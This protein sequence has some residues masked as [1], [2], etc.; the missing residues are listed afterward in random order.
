[1]DEP[2]NHL[3]LPA[4]LWL[5]DY[6]NSIT[7]T[8]IVIVS[9]DRNFLN[10]TV[11]EIIVLQGQQ[12][13]YHMGNYDEYL[14]STGEQKLHRARLREALGKKKQ[15]AAE[16]LEAGLLQAKKK[17]DEKKVAQLASRKKKLER[18]GM[19][20]NEAGHRFKLSRDRIGYFTTVRSQ[21]QEEHVDP[22]VHWRIEEP[23]LITQQSPLMEIESV[24]FSYGSRLILKNVTM[25]LALG[26][27][28]AIC[29][30]C[31]LEFFL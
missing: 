11:D 3:D 1:V 21:V 26:C 17:S 23:N 5:I 13:H 18:I 16:S 30:V 29:G 2:T 15:K 27:K 24:D 8:T 12:L 28:V 6:I 25:N 9:H 19:E 22:P 14:E 7:E 4:I 10:A 31:F 20:K